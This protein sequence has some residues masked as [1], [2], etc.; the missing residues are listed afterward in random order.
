MAKHSSAAADVDG[1]TID[2]LAATTGV[3]SRTIRFYQ[4]KHVL[5]PPRRKGRVA[6]YTDEHVERLKLIA[7]LQDRGLRLRAVRDLLQRSAKEGISVERWLG[8]RE[9]LGEAWAEDTPQL[10][11][12]DELLERLRH[13]K[14]GTLRKLVDS[15]MVEPQG[16]GVPR[17]YRLVSPGLIDIALELEDAG[18]SLETSAVVHTML[19]KRLAKA[20]DEI[21]HYLTERAGKGFGASSDPADLAR[22]V[23]ALRPRAPEAVRLMFEREIER[24]VGKLLEHTAETGPPQHLRRRKR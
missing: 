7:E 5:P 23:D 18:I 12:E 24:A 8:L 20:A 9:R 16:S 10:L 21:V 13:R 4:A 17:Q 22:A 6:V 19:Q 14:P 15:G 3:P 2:E 11:T 1:Y